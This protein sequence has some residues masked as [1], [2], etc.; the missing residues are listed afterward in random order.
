MLKE[1]T[2]T[3]TPSLIIDNNS[4]RV[5]LKFHHS[6]DAVCTPLS[7]FSHYASFHMKGHTWRQHNS[8]AAHMQ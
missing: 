1:L 7:D 2:V 4:Q 5:E 6:T 3:C 8:P